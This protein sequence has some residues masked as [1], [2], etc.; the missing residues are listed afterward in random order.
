M[1]RRLG[2]ALAVAAA[3]GG[4]CA[5]SPP[6]ISPAEHQRLVRQQLE[7]ERR[8]AQAEL[9]IERL[10]RR[11][12]ELERGGTPAATAVAPSVTPPAPV[13]EA[14]VAGWRDTRG[15]VEESDLAEL[16]TAPPA[17]A[18]SD[19]VSDYERGLMKLRDGD[20]AGAEAALLAF[21]QSA[22]DPELGDNAW[23]W[24]GEARLA[25]GDAT[26]AIVAYRQCLELYPEGNKVPD[27][28]L[29]LGHAFAQT[30][31]AVAAREVWSELV[32]RFPATAAAERARGRLASL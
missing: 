6:W 27:A 28:M 12:A 4:G 32:A 18:A 5:A 31:D 26:G 1:S 23:F 22:G 30:G 14:P 25:R 11:L 21:A 19:A 3:L 2:P 7:L 13:E 9:E 8:A 24:I 10:K 17:G 20:P 16:A 29:K 15:A